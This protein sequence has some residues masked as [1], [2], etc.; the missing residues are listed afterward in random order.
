MSA[1]PQNPVGLAISTLLARDEQTI[2]VTSAI[3]NPWPSSAMLRIKSALFHTNSM[4]TVFARECRA[5]FVK[6]S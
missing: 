5:I 3:S 4:V 1:L 6:A 2:R